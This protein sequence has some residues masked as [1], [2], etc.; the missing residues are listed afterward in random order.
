MKN[1]NKTVLYVKWQYL[2][3]LLLQRLVFHTY[4]RQFFSVLGQSFVFQ[5]Y[6]SA[7]YEGVQL[8]AVVPAAGLQGGHEA[9]PQTARLR[10]ELA[11]QRR[12]AHRYPWYLLILAIRVLWKKNNERLLKQ[13]DRENDNELYSFLKGWGTL[14]N[15]R[16]IK[17]C[18]VSLIHK[19]NLFLIK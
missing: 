7:G 6:C 13:Y 14:L 4:L 18:Y 15:Y 12:R 17:I 2:R 19:N 3:Q 16:P 10:L 5:H 11:P 9:G 1:S 8:R